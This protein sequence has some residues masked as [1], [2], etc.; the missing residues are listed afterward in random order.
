M[1]F[2]KI[3]INGTRY[4]LHEAQD[5]FDRMSREIDKLTYD[6]NSYK[7]SLEESLEREARAKKLYEQEKENVTKKNIEIRLLKEQ[8]PTRDEQGRYTAKPKKK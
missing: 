4:N 6:K 3:E 2:R 5:I 7:S 8:L 1:C